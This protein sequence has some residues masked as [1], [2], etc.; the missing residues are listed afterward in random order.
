MMDQL[1]INNKKVRVSPAPKTKRPTVVVDGSGQL[2]RDFIWGKEA[3]GDAKETFDQINTQLK[4]EALE[5]RDLTKVVNNPDTLRFVD[6]TSMKGVD[7]LASYK[8]KPVPEDLAALL[9]KGLTKRQRDELVTETYELH[10]RGTLAKTVLKMIREMHA[11]VSE[12]YTEVRVVTP[13]K[14]AAT[15]IPKMLAKLTNDSPPTRWAALHNLQKHLEPEW[16]ARVAT[17]VEAPGR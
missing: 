3:L 12:D 11:G 14:E 9:R 2:V 4:E 13:T 7:V 10:V 8:R 6:M 15:K 17:N 5:V 1:T 16:S